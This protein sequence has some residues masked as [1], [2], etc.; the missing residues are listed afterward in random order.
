MALL[1]TKKEVDIQLGLSSDELSELEK[2]YNISFLKQEFKN[3]IIAVQANERIFLR[4]LNA[5]SIEQVNERLKEIQRIMPSIKNLNGSLLIENFL[6]PAKKTYEAKINK[7]QQDF[8]NFMAQEAGYKDSFPSA[9]EFQEWFQSVLNNIQVNGK[10]GRVHGISGYVDATS[11]NQVVLKKLSSAQKKR[12]KEYI[13][14]K[15]EKEGK[16]EYSVQLNSESVIV[17]QTSQDWSSLTLSLKQK[18]VEEMMASGE[19]T[20]A[21]INQILSNIENLILSKVE[22]NVFFKSAVHEVL[23]QKDSLTKIF[24]GGNIVNGIAGILGEI[25]GLFY[26]KALLNKADTGA[27]VS[28]VGGINN[29]HED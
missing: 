16:K 10:T 22:D 28:W 27:T 29:P 5:N 19:M 8:A 3:Q 6:E 23:W 17:T 11:L 1:T 15:R 7:D 26:M 4:A 12:V 2:R 20:K 21:D 18:E 14:L 25:Q 13:K 24:Y 9:Q